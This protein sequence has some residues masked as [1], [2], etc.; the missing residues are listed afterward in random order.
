[1][2]VSPWL[3]FSRGNTTWSQVPTVERRSSSAMYAQTRGAKKPPDSG[4]VL[5][6][7]VVHR[8]GETER[9]FSMPELMV[10][11]GVLM[12]LL[13]VALP[14]AQNI[15][16]GYRLTADA[17]SITG[18]LS[19]ARI[20]GASGFTRTQFGLDTTANT[21][22]MA[23]WNKTF[24]SYQAEGGVQNLSAGDQFGYGTLAAPA[25]G[26]TTIA[27]TPQIIFNSR[28]FSVDG[29]GNP[30]GTAAI[31]I[32]DGQGSYCAITVSLAAQ[33]QVWKY[34]GTAWVLI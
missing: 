34:S 29:A 32:T 22:Q 31:Y 21:Y 7:T 17:R 6:S 11:A 28:G 26:Q 2:R 3:E 24:G 18:Q 16:R 27:Q 1:M 8:R 20:R 15:I 13:S 23:V 25:G 9:G 5:G 4:R 30:I 10:V 33:V 19:L 14:A 12:V